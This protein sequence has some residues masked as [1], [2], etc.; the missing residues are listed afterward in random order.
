MGG[1]EGLPVRDLNKDSFTLTAEGI[2]CLQQAE[3][4][5]KLQLEEHH[6]VWVP[7]FDDVRRLALANPRTGPSEPR[8]P[9]HLLTRPA[10]VTILMAQQN[11]QLI[12][13]NGEARK[14][15]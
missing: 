8:T 13:K 15:C 11:Q 2:E 5:A 1:P 12:E 4:S 7:K 14:G 9:S 6:G 3:E 10:S